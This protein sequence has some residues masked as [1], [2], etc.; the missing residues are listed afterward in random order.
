[1]FTAALILSAC[2]DYRVEL[3]NGY[4]LVRTSATSILMV[5]TGRTGKNV[6]VIDPHI[7]RYRVLDGEKG[8]IIVGYVKPTNIG[9][10]YTIT[11]I[12]GYFV[13]NAKTRDLR[14]GLSKEEW[15]AALRQHGVRA[16]PKMKKPSRFDRWF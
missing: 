3:P 13:L 8:H 10:K 1:M 7:S 15:R 5:T 11:T 12:G 9:L 16:E 4:Y 14:Q 2:G 6:I